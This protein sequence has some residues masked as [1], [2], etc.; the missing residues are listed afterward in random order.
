MVIRMN[1]IEKYNNIGIEQ[2]KKLKWFGWIQLI[3]CL[4]ITITFVNNIKIGFISIL[5]SVTLFIILVM[6]EPHTLKGE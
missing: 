1:I 6:S 4:F 2:D 5:S 3:I